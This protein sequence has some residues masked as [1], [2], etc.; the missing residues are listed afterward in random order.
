MKLLTIEQLSEL[1]SVKKKTIYDW[2]HRGAIPCVKVGRLLRFDPGEIE[3][4]LK[5][6]RKGYKS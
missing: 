6:N 4:W 1:I 3:R 5:G 2:T